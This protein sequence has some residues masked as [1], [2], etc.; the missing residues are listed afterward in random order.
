M[1]ITETIMEGGR[2][3]VHNFSDEGF[4]VRQNETGIVYSDAM[5]IVPCQYTYTETDIP[6]D[7]E[8]IITEENLY[9]QAG[10]ILFGE[11]E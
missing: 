2:E 10:H 4:C 9:A 7:P 5:D 3:F 6:L 11:V 1:L 8:Q